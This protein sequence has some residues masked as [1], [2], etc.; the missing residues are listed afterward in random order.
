MILLRRLPLFAL[1]F[2]A[3]CA[4]QP[5]VESAANAPRT[6][7]VGIAA[8]NDFH[9]NLEP[10]RQSVL[11]P[12]GKGGLRQIPAG[13]AAYLASA[14]DAV[15]GQ[16]ANRLTVAAGDLIGGTPITSALFVDEPAIGALSR[17]GLDFAAVGNHEFDVGIEELRRKQTGGCSKYTKREPCQV[18]KF[19]GAR[20]GYLAANVFLPDG[21]TLFPA[22]AL[23]QF[24]KGR[25]R[26]TVGLI[27][28]TLE[29][30]G[31]LIP[32]DVAAKVRFADEADTANALVD[33]LKRQGADA[34]V[35]LIHEGG[36]TTGNPDP[37][38]CE[39]LN[40]AI[41][42]ILDRLDPR[43]DVVV[44]GHTHWSYVC[45]YAKYNAAKPFLLTSAGVWG[46]LVTDITL[47]I[48]PRAGRVVAKKAK[49]VIVQSEAYVSPQKPIP[50]DPALPAFAP[51][52]DVKA[53]VDRYVEAARAFSQRKVGWLAAP[54][55]KSDGETQNTGGPLGKLI[56]DAQLAATRAAGAQ[57]SFMNPFGVR[58]SL[59]PAA[60]GSVTFGDIY[61]VQP[62]NN[63]LYTLTY[64]GAELKAILEQGFDA[65]GPEQ[66]L[67]P[68]AG[69]VFEYDR[70][71]PLGDRIVAMSL[72]G[73]LIDPASSY[74]VT[75]SSFL[76]NGG[77][78]FTGFAKGRD[79]TRGA[80]DIDALE[81]WL[82]ARP[83]RAG[84]T[85]AREIDRNPAL[86]TVR[87][88]TPPGVRYR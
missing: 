35:L 38:G 36:R 18:E 45:D 12:D 53:Y 34:V 72:D 68:S 63:D 15:R 83:P 76:A 59:T 13:G 3:A 66:I 64:T 41:R 70:A 57:I 39:G 51:R 4:A 52:A 50:V 20:F 7:T 11:T 23:R 47:D 73:K 60:D 81:A 42:P 1:P 9:G 84:P 62:F 10:P 85:D 58:R 82:A 33:G 6:V 78:T 25:D 55:A 61:A 29:D 37:N 44:S 87:S 31:A 2:L 5:G 40:S 88:T 8:I 48:D 86:N 56:A 80:V 19:D 49:N 32:P 74:R 54:L 16:Y 77:D 46:G 67:T 27:G 21:K 28:M 43:I 75:V 22:T 26:V 30:T 79:K 69:F 14:L 71:R 65:S 24:G 17:A